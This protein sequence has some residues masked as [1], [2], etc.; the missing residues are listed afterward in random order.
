MNDEEVAGEVEFA[1][2]VEFVFELAAHPIARL[3]VTH[4]SAGVGQLAQVTDRRLFGRKRILREA[5]AEVGERELALVGDTLCVANRF[6]QVAEQ[7]VHFARRTKEAFGI[8]VEPA[9]GGVEM[10]L[11]A[12]AGQ[13]VEERSLFALREDDVVGGEERQTVVACDID[14]EAI[15]TFLLRIEVAL[16]ID[17]EA[18]GKEVLKKPDRYREGS[19]FRVRGS[20]GLQE[21]SG[22]ST[23]KT[24][25]AVGAT[26][27]VAP[28]LRAFALGGPQL[29]IGDG[30]AQIAIAAAVG[31]EQIHA[32]IRSGAGGDMKLGAD[33]RSQAGLD[34]SAMEPRRA[35]ET[36]AIAERQSRLPE[37]CRPRH[38]L[39]GRRRTTEKAESTP[40]PQLDVALNHG[41]TETR[42]STR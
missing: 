40:R 18:I 35:V 5:I 1:D 20:R 12:N 22:I 34:G 3:A 14:K 25:Q 17:V 15:A 7:G 38:K 39:L 6:G 11:L 2:D 13:D 27:E 37:R 21:R 9:A 30:P 28:P 33:Q 10:R 19:G 26:L 16:Q 42:R 29:G 23:S 24:D 32:A 8:A 36:I 4:A 41:D 31:G